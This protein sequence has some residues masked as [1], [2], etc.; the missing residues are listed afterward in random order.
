MPPTDQ[1]STKEAGGTQPPMRSRTGN[2]GVRRRSQMTA[3]RTAPMKLAMTR[4]GSAMTTAADVCV[5]V[6]SRPRLRLWR[7]R[8]M[9]GWPWCRAGPHMHP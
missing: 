2:V 7:C 3:P 8:N 6:R 1:E 5:N 4:T 9:R